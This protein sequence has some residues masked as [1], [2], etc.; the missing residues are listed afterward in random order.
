MNSFPPIKL[1]TFS[2]YFFFLFFFFLYLLLPLLHHL[3][4]LLLPVTMYRRCYRSFSSSSRPLPS[5]ADTPFCVVSFSLLFSRFCSFS[6][7]FLSCPVAGDVVFPTYIYIDT[8]AQS[9]IRANTRTSPATRPRSRVYYP[10]CYRRKSK[11]RE[12]RGENEGEKSRERERKRVIEEQE[13]EGGGGG[14]YEVVVVVFLRG[15]RGIGERVHVVHRNAVTFILPFP[16]P[17]DARIF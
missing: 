5:A 2:T 8:D 6:A 7:P 11:E 17:S 14:G 16:A 15:P 3:L 1:A 12:D 13:R 9:R 4:L 10:R